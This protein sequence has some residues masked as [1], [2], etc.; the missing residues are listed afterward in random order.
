MVR[1]TSWR[2]VELAKELVRQIF[3][4]RASKRNEQPAQAKAVR[5]KG[6]WPC[7]EH[8]IN[9]VATAGG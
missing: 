2:R 9:K 7:L 3:S 4:G 1:V 6:I 5:L 8:S